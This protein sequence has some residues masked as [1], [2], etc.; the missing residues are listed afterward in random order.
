MFEQDINRTSGGSVAKTLPLTVLN[1]MSCK[2]FYSEYKQDI[3]ATR[4][5]RFPFDMREVNRT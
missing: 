1:T 2:K 3:F 4:A 5:P